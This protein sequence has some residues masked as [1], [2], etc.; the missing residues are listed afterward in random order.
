MTGRPWAMAS[1]TTSGEVSSTPVLRCTNTS[2]ADMRR[3]RALGVTSK[4]LS[5][6]TT[7]SLTPAARASRRR[8]ADERPLDH[9]A[10][11]H[12]QGV[13]QPLDHLLPAHDQGLQVA[14][15]AGAQPGEGEEHQVAVVEAQPPA[16][17]VAQGGRALVADDVDAVGDDGGLAQRGLGQAEARRPVVEGAAEQLLGRLRL[18]DEPV[19]GA[20]RPAGQRQQ[21][22]APLLVGV[23]GPHAADDRAPSR[24]CGRSRWGALRI[25]SPL[26]T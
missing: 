19:G 20:H 26:A 17:L 6:T 2:A 24:S 3:P 25:C 13:G 22:V 7:R 10:R 9:R 5:T 16:R 8:S 1:W 4:G 12:Q 23:G 14:L 21:E 15:G 11:Q 18:E